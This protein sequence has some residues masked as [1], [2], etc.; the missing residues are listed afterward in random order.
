MESSFKPLVSVIIPTYNSANYIEQTINSIL[1]Q[2]YQNFEIIVVDDS[3]TDDTTKILKRLSEVDQRI[4]YFKIEHAGIPSVPRNVGIKKANGEFIAF[5]DSDDLW[6]KYKL[7][8]QLKYFDKFPELIFVY[9]MSVTFGNVSIFSP[10][11]EVLPLIFKAVHS[12]NDLITH[13]NSIPLSTVLVKTNKLR[14]ING[15]DEDPELNIGEDYDC[16]IRLSNL[17][18][19]IFIPRIHAYYRIHSNQLSN[20]WE[21]NKKKIEY[22][23][24]KRN[25]PLPEYKFYRNKGFLIRVARN[26]VHVLT[27]I[28]IKFISFFIKK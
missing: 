14:E 2:S 9:S 22:L 1:D 10:S 20:N 23:A 8:S 18:K 13:G 28:C 19:F 16:W 24:K 6:T 26:S 25:I 4:L 15:F 5:L 17:G 27:F 12:R 3:S 21:T 11:Y 7:E